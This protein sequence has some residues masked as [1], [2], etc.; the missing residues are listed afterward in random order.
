MKQDIGQIEIGDRIRFRTCN[1]ELT[2]ALNE[3]ETIPDGMDHG[4]EA[5]LDG[6][7]QPLPARISIVGGFPRMDYVASILLNHER[8]FKVVTT[9]PLRWQ[10]AAMKIEM[11]VHEG[12]LIQ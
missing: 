2:A 10:E 11:W 7:V 3:W 1:L 5:I 12:R 4:A 8:W 6:I 9:P